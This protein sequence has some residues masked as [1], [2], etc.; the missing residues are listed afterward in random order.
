[1]KQECIDIDEEA[2]HVLE[3]KK[4]SKYFDQ[5][6]DPPELKSEA[7]VD[8]LL[9]DYYRNKGDKICF[10]IGTSSTPTEKCWNL[11]D[12]HDR[13]GKGAVLEIH[14]SISDSLYFGSASFRH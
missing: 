10:E 8:A 13:Y 1:M 5:T 6:K 4:S 12:I 7:E 3:C 14:N 2:L 9:P 11:F